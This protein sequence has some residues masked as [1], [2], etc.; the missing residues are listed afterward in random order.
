MYES[1]ASTVVFSPSKDPNGQDPKV[2]NYSF[3]SSDDESI[4]SQADN[5]SENSFIKVPFALLPTGDPSNVGDFI[6]F[7][8]RC[9]MQE[10]AFAF[11]RMDLLIQQLAQFETRRHSF[12][13]FLADITESIEM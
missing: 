12:D 7:L 5:A 9:E 6:L 4:A 10:F 2:S 13:Q 3:L 1:V 11:D 8:R